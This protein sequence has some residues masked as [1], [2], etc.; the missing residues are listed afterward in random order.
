M[1][2]FASAGG[3]SAPP[4]VNILD[5]HHRFIAHLSEQ[6]KK[7]ASS[8]EDEARELEKKVMKSIVCKL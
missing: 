5:G 3:G 7:D 4:L 2:A 1:N 6:E 8:P